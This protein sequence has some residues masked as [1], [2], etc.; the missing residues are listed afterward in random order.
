ML[1]RVLF[2]AAV[3]AVGGSVVTWSVASKAEAEAAHVSIPPRDALGG[4]IQAAKVN[5]CDAAAFADAAAENAKNL[6]AMSFAPF[7]RGERGWEIYAPLVAKKIGTACAPGESGFARDLAQWQQAHGLVADGVV[8]GA[9]FVKMKTDWQNARPFVAVRAQGVCPNPPS[10]AELVTLSADEGYKG[11]SVQLRRDV[12]EAY[13]AMV[14]A[15]KAEDAAIAADLDALDVF[16]GYRSPAYDDARCKRDGNCGGITRAKCS[17][18]RTGYTFDIVVGNAP[19]HSVDST[20]DQNR[21][22]MSRTPAYLWMVKNAERFGFVNYAFEPWHWEFVGG[23]VA[24]T[25]IHASTQPP[26]PS[27]AD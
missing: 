13:R 16:S 22:H 12:A 5:S 4:L 23:Q 6:T 24:P 18:H 17:S 20:N 7:G 21:L 27:S 14:A 2:A 15:A 26:K 8:G 9:T 1:K 25:L 3:F 19:G 11:K 10:N